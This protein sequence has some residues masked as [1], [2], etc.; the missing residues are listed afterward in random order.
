MKAD[1]DVDC[2]RCFAR[3]LLSPNLVLAL[4]SL[5]YDDMKKMDA[6]LSLSL[7][8]LRLFGSCLSCD[9]VFPSCP[10]FRLTEPPPAR[11]FLHRR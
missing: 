10:E 11:S 6:F 5:R 8:R 4:C 9:V 2:L 7:L 1:V 3:Q